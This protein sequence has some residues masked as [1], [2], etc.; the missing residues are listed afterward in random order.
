MH[1]GSV[2]GR[3]A[4]T[5]GVAGRGAHQVSSDPSS[6]NMKKPAAPRGGALGPTRATQSAIS[7]TRVLKGS[8][9]VKVNQVLINSPSPIKKQLAGPPGAFGS[10]STT[11]GATSNT[12]VLRGTGIGRSGM[13]QGQQPYAPL[14]RR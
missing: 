7:N 4:Y 9:V 8:G 13:I 3:G 2:A 10:M 14:K 1:T 11:Q 12:G 6:P 5:S